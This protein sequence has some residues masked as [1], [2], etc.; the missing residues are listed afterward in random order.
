MRPP[1]CGG[2]RAVGTADGPVGGLAPTD[3]AGEGTMGGHAG[4]D[5]DHGATPSRRLAVALFVS[6]GILALEVVGGL[7]SNSLALLSDA[8]HVLTDACAIALSWFASVQAERPPNARQ[9]YGFHRAGILAALANAA[10]L[11]A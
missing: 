11:I 1:C 9:T 3:R 7:A 4:H 5:H 2:Q 10:T 6:L 8:G